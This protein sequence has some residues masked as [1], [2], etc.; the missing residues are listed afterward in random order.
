MNP[1]D[2][3]R[4][5][6][7]RRRQLGLTRQETAERAGMSDSY[8]RYVE[9]QPADFDMHGL[10]QLAGALDTTASELLGGGVDLPPGTGRAAY[11]PRLE[12]MDRDECLTRISTH[13]LGRVA[14]TTA[15]GPAI[16][17]VNYA[18]VDGAIVFRTAPGS[19]PA[20]A[21]GREVAFEVDHFDE[22]LSQ[23]WSVLLV[24]EAER[25]SDPAVSRQLDERAYSKPWA[26]GERE[27]WV[28]IEPLKVTGR[29][30]LTGTA[31]DS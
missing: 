15:D 18:V 10:L 25:I 4:R 6:A 19:L 23:G 9:E 7:E 31:H 3:G 22:A 1:G 24:G 13:G 30:I 29:R 27:V 5:I 26:G 12:A 16:L 2:I 14:V 8:L 11:H 21:A 17:P 28:R 20:A